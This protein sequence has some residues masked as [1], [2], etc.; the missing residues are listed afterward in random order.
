MYMHI[1]F[2]IIIYAN[3]VND[4]PLLWPFFNTSSTFHTNLMPTRT[5]RETEY[6]HTHSH[7]LNEHFL[8]TFLILINQIKLSLLCSR[9]LQLSR[10]S[11]DLKAIYLSRRRR[12]RGGELPSSIC[13]LFDLATML[14]MRVKFIRLNTTGATNKEIKRETER[15]SGMAIE[16]S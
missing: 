3:F 13:L 4:S 14:R 16:M 8:K 5:H 6:T 1:F 7:S 9:L 11:T 10:S 15:E 2:G 12:R